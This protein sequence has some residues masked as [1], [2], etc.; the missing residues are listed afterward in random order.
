MIYTD[1]F[2]MD[3]EDK[4]YSATAKMVEEATKLIGPPSS[5]TP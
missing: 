3:T 1:L 4:Y 2:K 5:E